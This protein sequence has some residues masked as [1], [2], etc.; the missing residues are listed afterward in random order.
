MLKDNKIAII[1]ELIQRGEKLGIC[2]YDSQDLHL[3]VNDCNTM[4]K[5]L[6]PNDKYRYTIPQASHTLDLNRGQKYTNYEPNQQEVKSFIEDTITSLKA[7]KHEIELY[8]DDE[9]CNEMTVENALE[10][11]HTIAKRFKEATLPLR[12][13]RSGKQPFLVENEYDV[14]DLFHAFLRLYFHIVIP[15]EWTPH[16]AGSANRMDFLLPEFNIAI[17]IKMTRNDLGDKILGDQILKDIPHYKANKSVSHLFCFIYDPDEFIQ[18]KQALENDLVR[19]EQ[20]DIHV[21]IIS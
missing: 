3:W 21:E 9:I 11:L 16:H 10:T 4:R 6:F 20:L 13:R 2:R 15:E 5:R 1:Q 14:Q 12:K 8:D 19:N 7:R 17:E 18:N